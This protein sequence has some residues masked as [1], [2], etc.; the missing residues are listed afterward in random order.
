MYRMLTMLTFG[1]RPGDIVD[2]NKKFSQNIGSVETLE[3]GDV[4]ERSKVRWLLG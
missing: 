2:I 3:S 1:E 4:T